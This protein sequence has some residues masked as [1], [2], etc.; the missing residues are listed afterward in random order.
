ME[1]LSDLENLEAAVW[2]IEDRCVSLLSCSTL[3]RRREGSQHVHHGRF[4]EV[5][6]MVDEDI[7]ALMYEFELER[8]VLVFVPSFSL[9]VT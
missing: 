4:L 8:E 1:G 7:L 6:E 9:I 5:K 3:H 2:E